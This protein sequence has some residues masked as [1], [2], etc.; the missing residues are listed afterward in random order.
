MR[1]FVQKFKK[2]KNAKNMIIVF[3]IKKKE[4]T[5][6]ILVKKYS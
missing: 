3:R 4:R 6:K 1:D 2:K 5:K